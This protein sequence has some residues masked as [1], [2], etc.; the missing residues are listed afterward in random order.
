MLELYSVLKE[1]FMDSMFPKKCICGKWGSLLCENCSMEVKTNKTDLC[2]ICKK[3]SP[4]GRTCDSCRYKSN[5]TGVMIL[6][7]HDGVLKDIIWKYKYGFLKEYYGVISDLIIQKYGQFLIEKRF[8]ITYPPISKGRINWRGFNQSEVL[9]KEVARRLA[10]GSENLLRKQ[11]ETKSQVGLPRKNRLRN[12]TGSIS[13]IKPDGLL[14]KKVLIIDDVYTTGA[15]LEECAKILREN[16]FREVWGLV[17]S[18]D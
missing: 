18:R 11:H 5:L 2:P 10:L 13:Y 6:G 3:L 7:H 8:L 17:I 15:T 12:I 4:F 1:T 16:G 9:A 14:G